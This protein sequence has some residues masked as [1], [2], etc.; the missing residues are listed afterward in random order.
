MNNLIKSS[1]FYRKR[2][3]IMLGTLALGSTGYLVLRYKQDQKFDHPV[4]KEI[5]RLMER[6]QQVVELIGYP[7]DTKIG[8]RS[9]FDIQNDITNLYFV[10]MGP[11]G[12]LLVD[13]QASSKSL[14]EIKEKED[15]K[16]KFYLP[17]KE[18]YEKLKE[19]KGNEEKLKEIKV[20]DDDKFWKLESVFADLAGQYRIA[21]QQNEEEKIL[22]EKN[23]SSFGKDTLQKNNQNQF[24]Q[25]V[26]TP[27]STYQDLW[28]EHKYRNFKEN[29]DSSTLSETEQEERRRFRLNQL[30]QK[31]GYI[32]IW[33][34]GILIFGGMGTYIYLMK[35]KRKSI[36]NSQIH[37]Q[38]M[39]LIKKSSI[40]KNLF[41][42]TI[43]FT[44]SVRGAQIDKDAEFDMDIIGD[45]F[46]GIAKIKGTQNDNGTWNINEIVV[47]QK[48]DD[49]K[50]L[51]KKKLI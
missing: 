27:R 18:V 28:A 21:I 3:N 7:L 33:M 1:W 42:A 29:I 39:N 30:Y 24:V 12:T 9:V 10:V 6:N 51:Q 44:S 2:T 11:K 19:L 37:Q 5:I 49:G 38:S 48:S 46:N 50:I 35:N 4:V 17:D 13:A 20:N 31:I 15:E 25:N 8:L 26:I 32:R 34:F 16:K 45:K 43:K 23:Q 36:L 22:R 14:K 41:G 40:A 47:E